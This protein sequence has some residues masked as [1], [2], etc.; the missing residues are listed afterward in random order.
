MIVSTTFLVIPFFSVV[1]DRPSVGQSDQW[2]FPDFDTALLD[3]WISADTETEP[4]KE[5]VDKVQQEWDKV[6]QWVNKGA[7]K[8]PK[9]IAFVD[10]VDLYLSTLTDC[11]YSEDFKLMKEYA[12]KALWYSR[13]LRR[14]EKIDD[15]PL[16]VLWNVH[17]E[18]NEL[19]HI[20]HDQMFGLR[21]WSEFSDMVSD[22]SD[23]WVDYKS[24]PIYD[25]HKY[26]PDIDLDEHEEVKKNITICLSKLMDS[27]KSGYQPDYE[28]PCDDLGLALDELFTLYGA[29]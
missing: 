9:I 1:I 13:Y 2:I 27:M 11:F 21:E 10:E 12:F 28:I 15:Y 6:K 19:H 17:F 25:L 23:L 7:Q 3:I 5:K 16:D 24:I 14:S 26:F 22:F 20:I 18:Y 29:K 8:D 4:W